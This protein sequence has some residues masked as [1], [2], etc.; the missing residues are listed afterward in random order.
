MVEGVKMFLEAPEE[1][2][3]EVYVSEGFH[4]P[5][6]DRKLNGLHA[7]QVSEEVFRKM[8]DTS[9]PQG[10]LCVMKRKQY[11]LMT[12]CRQQ[13]LCSCFWKTSRIRAIWGQY[14]V[15]VRAPELTV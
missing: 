1:E 4:N 11:T 12:F 9:T 6:C 8:S 14:C 5:A 2:I 15:P 7:E 13:I 10:I 3:E